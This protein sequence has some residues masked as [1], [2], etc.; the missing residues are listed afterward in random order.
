MPY[1]SKKK[2]DESKTKYRKKYK[3]TYKKTAYKA[4]ANSS[5]VPRALNEHKFVRHSAAT[6]IAGT[7]TFEPGYWWS[8]PAALTVSLSD[9]TA[10]SDFTNLYDQYMIT[11]CVLEVVTSR[12][13]VPIAG[14]VPPS[15]LSMSM[16]LWVVTDV[17]DA[18]VPLSVSDF[19]ER[20]NLKKIP[21]G[22]D[23][24]AE[25]YWK[26]RCV[27]VITGAL[28]VAQ[29]AGLEKAMWLST[30]FTT[31]PHFGL[32][33]G[34]RSLSSAANDVDFSVSYSLKLYFSCKDPK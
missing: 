31:I 16:E 4:R 26:P 8:T 32:K 17:T 30:T 14:V 5:F 12:F 19:N 34:V 15:Q 10:S 2:S 6:A 13:A 27:G 20:G 1:T 24:K 28:G 11:S 23:G 33:F 3:S 25:F 18:N 29:P 9:V 21:V 7:H 22:M